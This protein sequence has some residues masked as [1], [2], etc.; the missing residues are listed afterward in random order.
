[1]NIIEL[2]WTSIGIEKWEMNT[3]IGKYKADRTS[4]SAETEGRVWAPDGSYVGQALNLPFAT[5]MVK[6]DLQE[7]QNDT[8]N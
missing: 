7:R 3:P 1:M 5:A 4:G 8:S 6:E 2:E